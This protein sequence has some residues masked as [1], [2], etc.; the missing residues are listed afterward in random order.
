MGSLALRARVAST[1]VA[2]D[3]AHRVR[4]ELMHVGRGE[5]GA[6]LG[7]RGFAV[8]PEHARAHGAA[9]TLFHAV[10]ELVRPRC[11]AGR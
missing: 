4:T 2:G 5:R 8:A 7:A 11:V 10:N 3:D 9:E 6:Q 1:R